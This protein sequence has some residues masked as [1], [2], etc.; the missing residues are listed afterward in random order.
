VA[1]DYEQLARRYDEDRAR[2]DVA[3]DDVVTALIASARPA[4]VLDIGCGTGTWLAAHAE[5]AADSRTTLLGADPS[6]GMLA[7]ARTKGVTNLVCAGAERLPLPDHALDYVVANFTFHHWAK[8]T[9]LDEVRRVLRRGG[10]FRIDNVEPAAAYGNWLYKF[11]PE[12]RAIDDARFW[13]TARIADELVTRGFDVDVTRDSGESDVAAT[14]ALAD[15]D[16]RVISQLADLDDDAYE[17]GLAQ[18]RAV[19]A[20]ADATVP[21]VWATVRVTAQSR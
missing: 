3:P 13:P 6:P 18:L 7:V 5:L 12:A 9:A 2:Y 11:F 15:A 20:H 4:R 17:R 21:L 10:V 16:R 1:T 14:E 19:A 8:A